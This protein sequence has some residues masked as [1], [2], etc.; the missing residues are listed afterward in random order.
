MICL[1]HYIFS[2]G[3]ITWNDNYFVLSV[4]LFASAFCLSTKTEDDVVSFASI[5]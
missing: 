5:Y 4:I 3:P 2:K 1:L